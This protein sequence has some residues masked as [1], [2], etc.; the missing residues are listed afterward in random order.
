MSPGIKILRRASLAL[1][2][3]ED[4]YQGL[5]HSAETLFPFVLA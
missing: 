4:L 5:I 2:Q 1:T 3:Y